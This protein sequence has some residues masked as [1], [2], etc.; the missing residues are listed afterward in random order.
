ME[1]REIEALRESVS[2]G[3]VLETS[4]YALDV[5]ESTRRAMKYRRG[6][7]II[8][9]THEGHGWF[10]PLSDEKGDIF[11]LVAQLN[12]LNFADSLAH[13]A[14]LVGKTLSAPAELQRRPNDVDRSSIADRWSRRPLPRPGSGTWR[15]ICWARD[16][17]VAVVREAIKHGLLREG[18]YGSM[19]A[20]HTDEHGAIVGWEER[21]PE[22]RGFATGG[23]KILFRLGSLDGLRLCVTEAAI[24]A[25]SLA[26]LE[27]MCA[28]TI[29][30]ST[31]GGW[32]PATD[33]ALRHLAS[34][35][36]AQIIG[37]TDANV[38]GEKFADRL[39]QLSEELDCGWLRL[40]PPADDWNEALREKARRKAK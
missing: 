5:K 18:P 25:M 14:G 1:R 19:W 15:Y 4:G 6:A 22:W 23:A 38:Q 29:Y 26:A 17:P 10:D 2:C 39:R 35:P 33:H 24:D 3:A 27:G 31:G 21:G 40:R 7:E 8:I 28:G 32:S 12:Q 13:V 34:R 20:A 36:N 16:I 11:A 37:A 9:V 30:L